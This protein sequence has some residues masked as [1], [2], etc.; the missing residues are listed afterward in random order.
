[1]D[2]GK[3]ISSDE[4]KKRQELDD[5]SQTAVNLADQIICIF[6]KNRGLW[7]EHFQH[8]RIPKIRIRDLAGGNQVISLLVQL[9]FR[10]TLDKVKSV[11]EALNKHLKE[12]FNI[13][14]DDFKVIKEGVPGEP[15]KIHFTKEELKDLEQS[16]IKNFWFKTAN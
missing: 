5:I 8:S 4:A 12:K 7:L 9:Q 6:E 3:Y 15:I 13:V 2:L 1:M 14:I 11:I 10:T 16:Y